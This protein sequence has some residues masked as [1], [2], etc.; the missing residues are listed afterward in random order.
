MGKSIKKALEPSF[1]RAIPPV[2]SVGFNNTK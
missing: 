1:G 2:F